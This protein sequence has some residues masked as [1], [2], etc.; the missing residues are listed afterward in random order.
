MAAPAILRLPLAAGTMVTGT[1]ARGRRVLWRSTGSGAPPLRYTARIPTRPR[2]LASP[3]WSGSCIAG[4]AL[5]D[6]VVMTRILLFPEAPGHVR[7]DHMAQV[8]ATSTHTCETRSARARPTCVAGC[9]RWR[10]VV[11]V[12]QWTR[13][14]CPHMHIHG[15]WGG[16]VPV[17]AP[18]TQHGL[19]PGRVCPPLRS[20]RAGPFLAPTSPSP[21]ARSCASTSTCA[22]SDDAEVDLDAAE[23]QKD[24]PTSV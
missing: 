4:A 8:C 23:Q 24:S 16:H 13:H 17:S 9:W 22:R 12:A 20:A 2:R 14:W 18:F 7:D 21:G 19:V 1:L 15:R 10:T 6:L 11:W 3:P 5:R